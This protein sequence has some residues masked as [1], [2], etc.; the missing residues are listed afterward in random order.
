MAGR[1]RCHSPG[2]RVWHTGQ[3]RSAANW[4]LIARGEGI[5]WPDLDEDISVESLLAGR[6]SGETQESLRQWLQRRGAG[7]LRHL[8]RQQAFP[9][10]KRNP[11]QQE[12]FSDGEDRPKDR[13][14]APG[15]PKRQVDVEVIRALLCV[16][17]CQIGQR[18]TAAV[19][20]EDRA[21]DQY[22]PSQDG[23]PSKTTLG[24]SNGNRHDAS[25]EEE[26]NRRVQELYPHQ[27]GDSRLG[28]HE[29]SQLR[30]SIDSMGGNSVTALSSALDPSLPVSLC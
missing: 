28:F 2:S 25:G 24:G 4:R 21:L 8:P 9:E 11:A 14:V 7:G 23:C 3:Q 13:F 1:S 18:A 5:H 30:R 16:A 17:T 10:E 6:R 12:Q 29:K 27:D 19:H 22:Q 20:R 26:P 15:Q